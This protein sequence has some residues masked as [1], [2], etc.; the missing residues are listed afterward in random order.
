M[1]DKTADFLLSQMY[2]S[3]VQLR[4]HCTHT[5]NYVHIL[6]LLEYRSEMYVHV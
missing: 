5:Y 2:V 4:F 3:F 6:A 1:Q